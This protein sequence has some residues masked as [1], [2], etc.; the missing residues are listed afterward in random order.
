MTNC[1]KTRKAA[2]AALKAATSPAFI[3]RWRWSQPWRLIESKNLRKAD[4]K[5]ALLAA[6]ANGNCFYTTPAPF[7]NG[8][9]EIMEVS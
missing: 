6:M 2:Y 7:G 5:C 3:V 4:Y 1:Y 8:L 9:L